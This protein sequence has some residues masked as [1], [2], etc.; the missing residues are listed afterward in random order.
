[1][2]KKLI[3]CTIIS[4]ALSSALIVPAFG[5]TIEVRPISADDNPVIPISLRMHWSQMFI[6]QL[7]KD[8]NIESLFSG[9]DLNAAIKAEDYLNIV[10][11]VFDA[12]Y[13]TT[14]DSMTREAVVHELIKLWADKTGKDLDNI[15]TI[16]M[17]IYSDTEKIDPKY[18]QSVTLAYMN[19]IA[20]GRGDGIFDPKADV[21]YGELAALIF[22][23][24]EAIAEEKKPDVETVA[25][26]RFETRGSYEIKDGKVVFDFELVNNYSE[27]KDVMLGS[28]QQFELTIT[29]EK[30]EEVYRYSDGKFFTLA[31]VTETINPGESLKWQ[32][33]WDMT[34]KE[35]NKLTSGKF[36]AKI[37]ILVVPEDESQVIEESQFTTVIEFELSKN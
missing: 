5:Q 18:N 19:D 2:R 27:P 8:Y 33:A 10:K 25:E 11:I 35:G 31:L 37:D 17:I 7:S 4:V 23:T 36:K 12:E 15:A 26:E 30:G 3:G 28:G 22:N 34:D 13:N 9:K 32:D 6:D 24:A 21:T 20:K 1:M 16:K 29:D 14:P